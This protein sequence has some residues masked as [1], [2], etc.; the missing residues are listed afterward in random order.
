MI[1]CVSY[2][3]YSTDLQNEKS[4]EDQL[5]L[6]REYA[7]R[8]G[9]TVV[10]EYCD[11]AK[12]G[13]SVLGRTGLQDLLA[14]AYGGKCDAVIVEHQDR[15]SRD[16]EDTAHI[17]KRL[18][19]HGIKLLEVH[20]GEA[21]TLTVGMKS[22]VA[23]MFREDNV[24]KVKRGMQGLLTA[25]KTAG[26]RAYGYRPV[27]GRPG[28]PEVVEE[29][30]DVVRRIFE[31]YNAGTSPKA[32]CRLLNAEGIAAPRGKLWAPSALLGFASRGTGILRS[33]IYR[34]R[35]VWNR[36]T[37][38]R[39]PDTGRRVSRVNPKDEW[40]TAEAPDLAIIDAETWDQVQAQL[41]ARSKPEAIV[42]QRRPQR[43]LSGLIKCG[44]CGSGM[45]VAGV[46]KSGRTRLRCSAHTNSGA[47]PNPRTFYLDDVE[48][49][50]IEGLSNELASPDQIT[51]YAK[52]WLEGR[53]K[54]AA[55]DIARRSKAETELKAIGKKLERIT[56]M[57]IDGLGDA[58]A[59]DEAAKE[60]GDRRD[61]LEAELA[62]EPPPSNVTVHPAAVARFAESLTKSRDYLHSARA[63]LQMTL[64][65][66]NDRGDLQKLIREVVKSITLSRTDDG[67]MRA[68]VST[69]LDGFTMGEQ[70]LGGCQGGSGGGT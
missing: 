11:A 52:A 15:L 1:R 56:G 53:H 13:A 16:Q 63:K 58:K 12:S 67:G 65:M 28:E 49:L 4:I 68:E 66:L 29:E 27:P 62:K 19:H 69:W 37:M 26:G 40:Q 9:Y 32:I 6:C 18:K 61:R 38:V 50:I 64:H 25:G 17:Y 44:A 43:L 14:A 21:N 42:R 47:C 39:D 3:R 48:E 7:T 2:A 20:G 24:L 46:D 60:L 22:I 30:A 55:K 41:E 59:L 31:E 57:L 10:A 54:E 5:A 45:A 34:G 36:V 33:P 23:E 51:R 70:A 8:E 35:I